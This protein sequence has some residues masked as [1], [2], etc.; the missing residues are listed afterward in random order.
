MRWG[1]CARQVSRTIVAR[2][3]HTAVKPV[4]EIKNAS[5]YQSYPAA[6][7]PHGS[8][9]PLLERLSFSL[10]GESDSDSGQCWSIVS[11]SSVART[12]VLQVLAGQHICIPPH[13]R[14][15]PYLSAISQSP[16]HAIKYVGFDAERGNSVGGT[17]VR[18][19]YLSAR[20]ESR[21]EETDFCVR[22]YLTG[23]TE[24]N[25]LEPDS[26]VEDSHAF[27]EIT[28]Q[29]NLLPLLQMPVANLSNGQTRRARIAKALMAKPAVLLLD[30][31]FMGLDPNTLRTMSEV[32]KQIA[33][34]Q[35]PHLIMSLRPEDGVPEWVSHLVVVDE[36]LRV[37]AQ[38]SKRQLQI[39]G[40]P[41]VLR[42]VNAVGHGYSAA[43]KTRL[44]RDGFEQRSPPLSPGEALV[45]MHGVEVAY[46]SKVVLGDWQHND[47]KS[48]LWWSLHRG[49]CCAIL[50]P[51][52]SGKTTM[53][54]LITSDH[55]Q[56][57][58]LPIEL[59][60]RSRLPGP[61]QP[62][63]SLFDIQRRMGHSSPEVHAFFPKQVSL[64]RVLESAWADA[65]LAK[66]KLN[67]DAKRRV[68]ACLRWFSKELNPKWSKETPYDRLALAKDKAMARKLQEEVLADDADLA[69]A[70]QLTFR[71]VSF[72]SQRLLLFL[73]AV[74]ASPDLVIMDEALSGI[75]EAIR[76]KALLFLS[77]GEKVSK[78]VDNVAQPS[79][80]A[81]I[82]ATV[83]DGLSPE[84]ALLVISHSKEDVPGC[85]REWIC[86]PEPGEGKQPRVGKLA[87]PL[88]LNPAAW[89]EIWGQ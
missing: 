79:M 54:S 48:G 25:A 84:Q 13:A 44:S 56:T 38:G 86:L 49:Q 43:P 62:G 53:L 59:F 37:I 88:E 33:V 8:N 18:G 3:Y 77:H 78:I 12:T 23:H 65:P 47:E 45:E 40:E 22:D 46:G 87:G 20:Y 5:F 50:G 69:W 85:I 67:E 66:P 24:L 27:D 70:S 60:G 42:I 29:L 71:E 80:L 10:S 57:Y 28:K 26:P 11:P 58:S 61:G 4:I 35:H 39:E 19:A 2:R 30:G 55:P 36:Q 51:N 31:P 52:G 14:S 34:K 32:L 21:R 15:Y 16:Q 63:I 89:G 83:I 1:A 68:N 75:D 74:V 7:E 76:D 9:A 82:G 17:S 41:D 64:R 81:R 73:R 6:N 72:S